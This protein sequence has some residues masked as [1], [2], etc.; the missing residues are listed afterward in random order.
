MRF[1]QLSF[2]IPAKA[3]IHLLANMDTCLRRYDSYRNC[4]SCLILVP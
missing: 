2:V 4:A 1:N 3:G